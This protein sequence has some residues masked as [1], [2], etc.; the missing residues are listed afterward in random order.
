MNKLTSTIPAEL[1][2][3]TNLQYLLLDNNRL[4]DGIPQVLGNL[5]ALKVL[6]LQDNRLAG[7]IP[8][9]FISLVNLYNPGQFYG[10]DGLDLDYNFLDVPA[11]YPVPGN[12]LHTLLFQKDPDWHLRQFSVQLFFLPVI[13]R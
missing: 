13:H 2:N 11:G 9:S 1:G 3:L 10:E 4:I 7:D 6:W 12:P 5:L 8:P